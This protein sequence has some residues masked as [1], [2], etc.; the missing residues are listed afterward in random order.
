MADST[1]L[2]EPSS[3]LAAVEA[4]GLAG[5]SAG[6][7]GDRNDLPEA[8]ACSSSWRWFGLGQAGGGLALGS[9]APTEALL[10]L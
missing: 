2:G 3:A 9:P 1:D 4:A 8:Q 10:I 6:G 7:S 5:P